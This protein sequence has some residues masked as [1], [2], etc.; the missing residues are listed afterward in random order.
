MRQIS[1]PPRLTLSGFGQLAREVHLPIL[2]RMA[3]VRLIAIADIQTTRREEAHRLFPEARVYE[4]QEE[5]LV[6][7]PCD[8][9]IISASPSVHAS[10]AR[11]AIQKS[12]HVYLEKPAAATLAEAV[13]LVETWRGSGLVGMM[14]FNYRF[15]RAIESMRE[16]MEA[17]CV[18][19]IQIIRSVFSA[20]ARVLPEWKASRNTGGGALLDLG[21]HHIDLF[22]YLCG[23]EIE[24]VQAHVRSGRTEDDSVILQ[25]T[26]R[27]GV[28]IQSFFSL[29][30]VEEDIIEVYGDAGKLTVD[31]YAL[32][33]VQFTPPSF[34]RGRLLRFANQ[35]ASVVPRPGWWKKLRSPWHEP[36][37]EAAFT[38]FVAAMRGEAVRQY[39]DF[40]DGLRCQVVIDA[41]ER[42]AQAGLP[43]P[44]GEGVKV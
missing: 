2:R 17:G 40:E 14:G 33:D 44:C 19:R 26:M 24:T 10:L 43:M 42:S 3:G 9:V 32:E 5:M 12:K 15:S 41:A 37:Y 16:K 20:S 7:S 31:R 39:P 8:G 34:K 28:A 36:S 11:G 23:S 30:A 35:V 1:D 4:S 22:R 13:R 27:N 18:G 38:Q 25:M 6:S 29:G 21:S